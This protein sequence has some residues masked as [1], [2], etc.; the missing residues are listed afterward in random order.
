MKVKSLKPVLPTDKRDP[1][2]AM[3]RVIAS[4]KQIDKRLQNIYSKLSERIE[5]IPRERV[6]LNNIGSQSY[7]Y[8]YLVDAAGLQDIG[9]YLQQ[10]IYDE[11]LGTSN[12]SF[13][14]LWFMNPYVEEQ[15]ER[16]TEQAL[17][18]T[19]NLA[20]ADAVGADLSRQ[21]RGLQAEFV[22]MSPG[23]Q[24]RV[25]LVKNRL[26]EE[27]KG[28]SDDMKRDL[29]GTLGR[30]MAAGHGINRIKKDIRERLGVSKSRAE[31]IVRTEI[32][33]AYRTAYWDETDELNN[34]VWE[35][36]GFVTR[37][38][39]YSALMATTRLSHSRR[40]GEVYTTTEVREFYSVDANPINCA[41]T[42]VEVLVKKS[43]GQVINSN[44][45]TELKKQKKDYLKQR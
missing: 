20:S 42:Q 6:A 21:I 11:I 22:L 28:F 25:N 33:N 31:R 13:S 27:M 24:T 26:F 29:G 16:A 30:G 44:I 8:K 12:G 36:S 2:G 23:Y 34:T 45:V 4:Y 5:Q 18:S 17:Q 15:Y 7:Q 3:N 10:L 40:H 1:V 39:W 43:D 19:M 32:L 35:G 37:L 9:T 41:C 14:N 38:L